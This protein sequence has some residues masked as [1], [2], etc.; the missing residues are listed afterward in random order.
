MHSTLKESL[1]GMQVVYCLFSVET[2]K[3][4]PKKIISVKSLPNNYG[5]LKLSQDCFFVHS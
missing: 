2:R 1:F 4:N 5:V 3:K